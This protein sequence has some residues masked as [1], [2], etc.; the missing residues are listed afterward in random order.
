M[1]GLLAATW[2]GPATHG[3]GILSEQTTSGWRVRHRMMR[4]D[5]TMLDDGGL[6]DVEVGKLREVENLLEYEQL[7]RRASREVDGKIA[8]EAPSELLALT[9]AAAGVPRLVVASCSA[10]ARLDDSSVNIMS[11]SPPTRREI[12]GVFRRGLKNLDLIVVEDIVAINELLDNEKPRQFTRVSASRARYLSAT[13]NTRISKATRALRLLV[14]FTLVNKTFIERPMPRIGGVF[15]TDVSDAES[16]VDFA[17]AY[18]RAHP[19]HMFH[20]A[21]PFKA[22]ELAAYDKVRHADTWFFLSK[23]ECAA[24]LSS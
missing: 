16:A 19:T 8:V 14:P 5:E 6:D 11:L 13:V 4:D 18:R 22:K 12:E 9:A 15:V 17:T 7:V 21:L 24:L 3:F 10:A 2:I 20:L 1:L 23:V